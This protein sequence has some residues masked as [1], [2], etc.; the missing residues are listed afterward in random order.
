VS[1]RWLRVVCVALL[2]SGLALDLATPQALIIAILLNAPIALSSLASDSRFT[3]LLVVLALVADGIGGYFNGVSVHHWD[4]IA[5]GNRELAAISFLIVG[6]DS[7]A[8]QASAR[9]AGALAA[10][11]TRVARERDLRRAIEAIR[12]FTNPELIAR[13]AVERAPSA[14]NVRQ[15]L[16]FVVDDS[17]QIASNYVSSGDEVV[18]SAVRPASAL[19]SLIERVMDGRVIARIDG[20]DAVSRLILET[21]GAERAIAAPLTEHEALLGVLIVTRNAEPFE[22]DFEESLEYYV[23]QTAIALAQGRLFAQ[24][25]ERN[26][27]LAR[28]NAVLRE[29]GNVIRDIVYALSHDLRTPLAAAVLTLRQAL[30]GKYGTLPDPAREIFDRMIGSNEELQRLAETLLLV[31]RYE[32]NDASP[33]RDAVD[34]EVVV[35]SVVED[36]AALWQS[37]RLSV[38]VY[39]A[40]AADARGDDGELRRAFVNLLANAIKFTPS[41]GM[42]SIRLEPGE[43]LK[44]IFEDDGFGVPEPD[45]AML[46]ERASRSLRQGAGSGLGLYLVRRIAESHGGHIRYAPRES[47]GSEFT[48][49]LPLAREM[50]TCTASF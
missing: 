38:N 11:A 10:R 3:R 16:L 47:G 43:T 33:R 18:A 30:D 6:G 12:D 14:L 23:D 40:G 24:L 34:V 20:A 1:L 44:V 42:I 46:F 49:E 15:A 45:R 36:L 19:V 22:E 39:G 5:V 27:A 48:F 31:S 28:A 25:G 4:A 7:I 13:Q 32:S 41:G 9:R 35:R 37:K 26:E 29:R 50:V 2:L 17:R 8:G 21:L